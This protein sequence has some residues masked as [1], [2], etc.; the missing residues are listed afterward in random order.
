LLQFR[1][2]LEIVHYTLDGLK[3]NNDK[4]CYILEGARHGRYRIITTY[5]ISSYRHYHCAFESRSW[6]DQWP[7]KLTVH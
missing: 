5:A 2:F 7:C 6:R 4:G 1:Q 3:I